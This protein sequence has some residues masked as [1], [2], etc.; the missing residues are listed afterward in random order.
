MESSDDEY[1][2]W[3]LLLSD[4]LAEPLSV[5][6]ALF[7]ILI[8]FML[9]CS[10]FISGAEVAFFSLSPQDIQAL[11]DKKNSAS[12][13]SLRLLEKPKR[14]LATILIA[15]NF[16]NVAIIIFSTWLV[17]R[18]LDIASFPY[19]GLFIETIIVT[20][21]IIFFGEVVPKVFASANNL[22]L[23]AMMTVPLLFLRGLFDPL[24]KLMVSSSKFIE[25]RIKKYQTSQ[26]L[27]LEDINQA[28]DL[29]VN[30]DASEQEVGI[31]KGIVTFGNISVKQIMRSRVDMVAFDIGMK[32]TDLLIIVKESGFSRI[33]VY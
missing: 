13:R 23:V 9:V 20:F 30:A 27:S 2:R 28:I 33:P 10:A 19:L 32:F 25:K 24:S 7:I 16:I 22:K 31:L 26:S 1:D 18:H 17:S 21:M 15:N 3:L 12:T 6:F 29:A 11:E 8:L 14:L 5:E 4:I